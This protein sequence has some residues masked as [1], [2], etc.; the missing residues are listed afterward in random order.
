[1]SVSS[2]P[3]STRVGDIHGQFP[4]LLK[5]FQYGGFPPTAKYLFLGDY[6]DRGKFVRL[7]RIPCLRVSWSPLRQEMNRVSG[8]G[9][10]CSP[11]RPYAC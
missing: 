7:L 2:W 9:G 4:D 1:M 3:F 10:P 11:W 6:V 5:L 8:G